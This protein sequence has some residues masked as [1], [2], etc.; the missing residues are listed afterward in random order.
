MEI[1]RDAK[2]QFWYIALMKVE[3][4]TQFEIPAY[5]A[6]TARYMV[7]KTVCVCVC[8]YIYIYIYI[9]IYVCVCVCVCVC[10]SAPVIL[11]S[12]IKQLSLSRIFFFF[13]SLYFFGRRTDFAAAGLL[14]YVAM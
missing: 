13:F 7:A 9:Y 4:E 2:P 11:V 8:V 10:V 1:F 5:P 12:V 6:C 14:R 3:F